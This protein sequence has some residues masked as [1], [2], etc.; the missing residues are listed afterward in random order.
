VAKVE[1][2][3]YFGAPQGERVRVELARAG[4]ALAT[5]ETAALAGEDADGRTRP[6]DGRHSESG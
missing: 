1:A 6:G 5:F 4:E 2:R 3:D